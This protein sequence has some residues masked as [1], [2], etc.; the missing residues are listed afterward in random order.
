MDRWFMDSTPSR[1]FPLYSRANAGEVMPDPASPLTCDL[2]VPGPG[3]AGWSDA[4]VEMGCWDYDM[5]DAATNADTLPIFGGYMYISMSLTRLFGVRMPGLTPEIVDQQYFGEMAGIPPYEW[6]ARPGDDDAAATSKLQHWL[7]ADVFGVENLDTLLADR[8]EVMEIVRSRG[9]LS[10]V[11]DNGLVARLR[12]QYD[13]FRRLFCRHIVV[14]ASSGIGIGTLSAVCDLVDA[15]ELVM[16]LIS[17][18]GDVDSAAPAT[19]MWHL[20]RLITE[21]PDL[22]VAFEPGSFEVLERLRES[23]SER[24]SH[25]LTEFSAFL[26]RFG[27]RGPNEWEMR[28]PTWATQPEIA[29]AAIRLMRQSGPDESPMSQNSRRMAEREAA[30]NGARELLAD[31]P[32][33][34][35]AQFEAGLRAAH[36]FSGGRERSKTTCILL[37]HELRLFARELGRRAVRAGALDS[38]EQ[39]FMLR[40]DELDDFIANYAAFSETVRQRETGYRELF[41]LEPPFVVV[42]EPPPVEQWPRRSEHKAEVAKAGEVLIGIPGCAGT[43]TGRARVVFNPADPEAL[44]RGEVLIAPITDPAWTPLFVPAAAVVVNVGAQVSHAVI[45]SRELGIPCVVSVTD[46]TSKIPDDALVRVDGVAGTV[47]V[48]ELP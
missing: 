39:V 3:D 30:Q 40:A 11:S 23:R 34:V 42:S 26:E 44:Q 32:A 17:G 27:S 35:K 16:P 20:S 18:L 10:V 28:S 4:Y 29:L 24:A 15:P 25:F 14:S 7:E 36:L 33:E 47:T 38:V 5:Y 48:L 41:A 8:E 9:D 2:G 22:Q 13:L 46:A 1:K 6:E 19:S 45:V 21:A 31:Q 37:V 12:G 43:V